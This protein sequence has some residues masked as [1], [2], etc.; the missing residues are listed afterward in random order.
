MAR[1]DLRWDLTGDQQKVVRLW[2]N[3]WCQ[4]GCAKREE[5]SHLTN[6]LLVNGAVIRTYRS[7]AVTFFSCHFLT[8]PPGDILKPRILLIPR[9][10]GEIQ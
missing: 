3:R 4:R 8:Q 2:A 5:C 9:L 1:T 6:V 10:K 7:F